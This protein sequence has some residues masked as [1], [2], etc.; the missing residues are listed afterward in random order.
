[1]DMKN[2]NKYALGLAII[3]SACGGKSLGE[4]M[5]MASDSTASPGLITLATTGNPAPLHR[6][7]GGKII[8]S[9]GLQ[10]KAASLLNLKKKEHLAPKALVVG[11]GRIFS[12]VA[13]TI[14]KDNFILVE[15]GKIRRMDVGH[16]EGHNMPFV[17]TTIIEDGGASWF[18]QIGHWFDNLFNR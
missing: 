6:E 15:G 11:D 8:S 16:T 14:T 13:P 10:K 9:A 2:L 17:V 5:P 7:I 12:M 4:M 1:M 3:L 18:A